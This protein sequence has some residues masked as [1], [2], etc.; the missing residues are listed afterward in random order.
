[1]KVLLTVFVLSILYVPVLSS[2]DGVYA[3]GRSDP[4]MT[5][6]PEPYLYDRHPFRSAFEDP[7]FDSSDQ[8]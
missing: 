2:I 1:M 6:G 7:G 5:Q 3:K 8:Q 4:L